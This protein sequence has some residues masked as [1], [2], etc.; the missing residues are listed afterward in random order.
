MS[1]L[2]PQFA[3]FSGAQSFPDPFLDIAT[4]SM[5]Q[6]FSTALRWAEYIWLSNGMYRE[7]MR[8]LIAYFITGVE[9]GTSIVGGSGDNDK[10]IDSG[11]RDKWSDFLL[12]SADVLMNLQQAMENR[13]CYANAFVSIIVPFKRFLRCKCGNSYPLD[14]VYNNP[15]FGFQWVNLE[16][17]SRCPSCNYSGRMEVDDRPHDEERKIT[18]KHWSVHEIF[19][20]HDLYTDRTDYFW[21][22]PEDYKSQIRR[23]TLFHLERC[24]KA[25]LEAVRRNQMFRF[26]P[27]AI[28]HLKEPT[29]CGIRNR[30][31]A[32]PR[33]L[34]NFRQVYYC[35]VLRRYNEAIALDYVIPFRLLTP[36]PR[37]GS[38]GG[39]GGMAQMTDPMMSMHGGDMRSEMMRMLRAR[40]RDPAGWHILPFPV[41]YQMLGGD[42]SKLAPTDMIVQA[43]EQLLNDV[44]TPVDMYKGTLTLQAAPVALRLFEA[45]NHDIVHDADLFLRWSVRQFSRIMNWNVIDVKLTRPTMA[46][47]VS[48]QMARLQML[49]SGQVSGTSGFKSLGLDW[50]AEQ[51]QLA[52]DARYQQELQERQQKQME[53]AGLT[54]QVSQGIVPGDAGPGGPGG[55]GGAPSAGGGDPNAAGGQQPGMA[56]GRPVDEFLA[57][58][59]PDVPISP[60]ELMSMADELANAMLGLPSSIKRQ[61]LMLLKQKHEVLHS[62][63][64][65][66]MD[67]IRQDAQRQGGTAMMQQT[68]GQA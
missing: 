41:Q 26:H 13:R 52:D 63:V 65:K 51:R 68:F 48:K 30:G 36:A 57:Q 25:V 49:M 62:Q 6:S 27:D 14:V 23:G 60:Q 37:P 58:M 56:S 29:L 45:S 67:Q 61:Q 43:N 22:I 59:G 39:G 40:R 34:S 12:T 8:R 32:I 3:A 21:R 1:Y 35:Q 46:D 38:G 7:A 17:H 66:R 55:P 47:D 31:W 33:V 2:R 5:P 53:Q 54:A 4:A 16:F 50:R 42:A 18:Y 11:E 64:I 15:R 20:L 28:L 44:G 24:P 19:L 10:P 9:F